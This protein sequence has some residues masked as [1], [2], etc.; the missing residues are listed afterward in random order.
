[1]DIMEKQ[2]SA[3][4]DRPRWVASNEMLARGLRLLLTSGGERVKRMRR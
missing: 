3:L 1:M 4:V 2:G